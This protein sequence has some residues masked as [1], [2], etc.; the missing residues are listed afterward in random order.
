MAE[1]KKAGLTFKQLPVY[2]KILRIVMLVLLFLGMTQ[3]I[4]G[5]VLNAWGVTLGALAFIVPAIAVAIVDIILEK[6]YKEKLEAQKPVEEAP[7]AEEPKVEQHQEQP[8]VEDSWVCP[9]CGATMTGKFCH[10]CGTKKPDGQVVAEAKP[11]TAAAPAAAVSEPV[12]EEPKKSKKGLI[13]GLSV[14]GGVLLLTGVIIGTVFGI[15]AL[16]GLNGGGTVKE[17]LPADYEF[18]VPYGTV[19]YETEDT[20]TGF[21]FYDNKDVRVYHWCYSNS[22]KD[23]RIYEI[24]EGSY[25]YTKSTQTIIVSLTEY[26]FYGDGWYV[27]NYETP[28]QLTF[29]I[30]TETKMMYSSENISDTVVKKVTYFTNSTSTKYSGS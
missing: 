8:K 3:M 29:K 19:D 25:S 17:S 20:Q 4:I 7:K 22:Y 24:K 26:Q 12:E 10:K 6:K 28:Q 11:V 18:T 27:H 23:Y 13:I 16:A 2:C 1:K 14:G 15:K 21:V 30:K 9:K 5:T